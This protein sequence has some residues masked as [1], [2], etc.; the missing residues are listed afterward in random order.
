M[1]GIVGEKE[2]NVQRQRRQACLFAKRGEHDVVGLGH[3][4]RMAEDR[5]SRYGAFGY[6][7]GSFPLPSDGDAIVHRH[8][9]AI[10]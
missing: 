10:F 4:V 9:M 6:H 8:P 2:Q 3:L 5:S 7:V 1:L